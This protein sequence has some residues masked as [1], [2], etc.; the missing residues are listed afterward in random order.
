MNINEGKG[1]RPMDFSIKFIT[2]KSAGR[3][4][5]YVHGSHII[6]SK[7]YRI[8]FSEQT[9]LSSIANSVGLDEMPH[10]V[11]FHQGLVCF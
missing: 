1:F 3:S 10:Y 5:V 8:S 11:A 6:I 9:I 7:E 2:I 4:S